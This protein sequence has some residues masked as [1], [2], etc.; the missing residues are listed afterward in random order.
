MTRRYIVRE[1]PWL[2]GSKRRV[3]ERCRYFHEA[4]R[5]AEALSWESRQ[6]SVELSSRTLALY[7]NGH[8][9]THS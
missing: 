5:V 9:V 4:C 3:V 6:V 2:R 1:L 7:M 8:K